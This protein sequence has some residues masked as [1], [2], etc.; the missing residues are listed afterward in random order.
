MAV[1]LKVRLVAI[2]VMIAFQNMRSY[3]GVMMVQRLLNLIIDTLVTLVTKVMTKKVNSGSFLKATV[4][5]S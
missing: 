3:F 1:S 4:I 2:L 5:N